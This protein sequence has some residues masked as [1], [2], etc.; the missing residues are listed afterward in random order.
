MGIL[1]AEVAADAIADR[2]VVGCS[3]IFLDIVTERTVIGERPVGFF[4]FQDFITKAQ[5]QRVGVVMRI[6]GAGH[7]EVVTAV[8]AEADGV[9]VD[10]VA[11]AYGEGHHVNASHIQFVEVFVLYEIDIQVDGVG[12]CLFKADAG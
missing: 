12:V 8:E 3:F 4:F 5:V 9:E 11:C 7:R 10:A 2:E 1:V 6:F